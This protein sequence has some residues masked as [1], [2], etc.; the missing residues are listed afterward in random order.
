MCLID[1]T[2]LGGEGVEGLS[3]EAGTGKHPPHSLV[4]PLG[5]TSHL[6]MR[7]LVARAW[8]KDPQTPD[9]AGWSTPLMRA[10][11]SFPV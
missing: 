2:A 7:L 9:K 1:G 11:C 3:F 8:E 6:P 5:L 10:S 4:P